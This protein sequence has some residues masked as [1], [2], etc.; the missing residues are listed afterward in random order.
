MVKIGSNPSPCDRHNGKLLTSFPSSLQ[1]LAECDV[2]YEE[3]P[4]WTEDISGCTSFDQLPET[5]RKYITRIEEVAGD[6]P[7]GLD[8]L[9]IYAYD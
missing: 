8:L 1:T 4:A 5:A 2:V 7:Q 9:Y 6:L 3:I